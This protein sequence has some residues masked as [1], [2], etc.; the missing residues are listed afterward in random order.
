MQNVAKEAFSYLRGVDQGRAVF[1]VEA[2][3]VASPAGLPAVV[4]AY[5]HEPE[6]CQRRRLAVNGPRPVGDGVD[7]GAHALVIDVAVVAVPRSCATAVYTQTQAQQHVTGSGVRQ[8]DRETASSTAA[9]G[10]DSQRH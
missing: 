9:S 1:G 5:V 10:T 3:L 7:G 2:A 4:N 6:V 8:G